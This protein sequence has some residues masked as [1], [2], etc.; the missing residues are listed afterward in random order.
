MSEKS[1]Y[2]T[3]GAFV[4]GALLIFVAVVL[5][6]LGSGFGKRESFVM[7]FNAA[8]KGLSAGAPV[9]LRGVQ[10]GQVTDVDVVLDTKTADVLVVVKAEIDE[11]SIYYEGDPNAVD[12]EDLI[13]R[14][15]RAQLNMQSLVTGLLYIEMDFHP[16]TPVKHY[17]LN[18]KLPQFPTVPTNL[19]RLAT[20]LQNFDIDKMAKRIETISDSIDTLVSSKEMQQLPL[21][22]NETLDSLKGLSEKMQTQ[23]ASSG[24]RLDAMLDETTTTIAST[25]SQL[26]DAVQSFENSMQSLEELVSSDST[27]VYQ[28][29][30]ALNEVSRASR[31]LRL[32]T[33]TLERQPESL[34][35]G[36]TG[37]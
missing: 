20:Q 1:Q 7:V 35:R 16:D 11:T 27:T 36:R 37:D 9:A 31:S 14:G 28:M 33:T 6:L 29:N 2:A 10:I 3:T 18:S 26:N 34:I 23:L 21:N 24:P 8:A 5:Y 15:L 4:V 12:T 17:N 30:E 22:M 13:K 25:G 32:L 19:E